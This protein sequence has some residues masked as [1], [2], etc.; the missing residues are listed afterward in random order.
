M[1]VIPNEV[2]GKLEPWEI[3]YSKAYKIQLPVI[4]LGKLET[5]GLMLGNDTSRGY[6]L[7]MICAKFSGGSELGG[8]QAETLYYPASPG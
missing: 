6:C 7:E 5:A 8:G 2:A 1:I 3:L 4:E